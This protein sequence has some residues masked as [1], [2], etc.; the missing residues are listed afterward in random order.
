MRAARLEGCPQVGQQASPSV[1]AWVTDG[2]L[3][4]R[5]GLAERPGLG[6]DGQRRLVAE[7]VAGHGGEHE[8][9]ARVGGGHGDRRERG[10][11]ALLALGGDHDRRRLV[12]PVDR[13]LLGH[14]VGVGSREPGGAHEDQRLG[15]Q[16]DVLLVLGGVAGDRLVAELARA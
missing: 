2:P 4:R 12:G 14:V 1:P 10:A 3:D 5:P 8:R 11:E 6:V 7:Q 16:V 15:R 13:H 9:E